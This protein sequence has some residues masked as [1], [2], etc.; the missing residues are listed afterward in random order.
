MGFMHY[1]EGQCYLFIL[2]NYDVINC[3]L[4]QSSIKL[5][6]WDKTKLFFGNVTLDILK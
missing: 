3:N 6:T 5:S 4:I 1:F 2:K